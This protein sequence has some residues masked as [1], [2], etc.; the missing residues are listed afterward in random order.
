M[1]RRATFTWVDPGRFHILDY[2]VQSQ[3]ET[4]LVCEMEDGAIA[5]FIAFWPPDDFIHMLYI[6]T[7]FQGRGLGSA[8]LQALP[9]W[10]RRRYRLKCLV[11]NTRAREFYESIG[12]IVSGSGTS[13]EGDYNDML[14]GAAVKTR[15]V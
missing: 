7:E 13:S 9:A 14:L 12:F 11:K 2:T 6:R 10:P 1:M 5:G 15:L 3:G 8:L 4:V